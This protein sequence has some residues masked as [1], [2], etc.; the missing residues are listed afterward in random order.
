[1]RS[2][3]QPLYDL[4]N[5]PPRDSGWVPARGC[6]VCAPR[7]TP[8]AGAQTGRPQAQAAKHRQRQPGPLPAGRGVCAVWLPGGARARRGACADRVHRGLPLVQGKRAAR[9]RRA[10]PVR[11]PAQS[12]E[13]PR[14]LCCW[15]ATT[16]SSATSSSCCRRRSRGRARVRRT[17]LHALPPRARRRLM[18]ACRPLQ[19]ARRVFAHSAGNA[20]VRGGTHSRRLRPNE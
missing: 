12:L 4:M 20:A 10:H 16:S 1:M 3:P 7:A 9:C 2:G 18:A 19:H 15:S 14:S 13:P 6:P 11:P 5:L 17:R 8:A